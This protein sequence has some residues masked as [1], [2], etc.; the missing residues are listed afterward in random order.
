MVSQN[1]KHSRY[2]KNG[3]IDEYNSNRNHITVNMNNENNAPVQS[4]ID[5][6][7]NKSN[8]LENSTF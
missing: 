2:L 7:V 4:K 1:K 8:V 5:D 3:F 6:D